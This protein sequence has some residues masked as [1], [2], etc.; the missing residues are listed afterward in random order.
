MMKCKKACSIIMCLTRG[1][2]QAPV[3]DNIASAVLEIK[4]VKASS[5]C[6]R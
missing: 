3:V 1:G 4:K 2:D 5:S 6:L